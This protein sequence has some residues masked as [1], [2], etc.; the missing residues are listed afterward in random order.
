[1]AAHEADLLHL[2]VELRAIEAQALGYIQ[3]QGGDPE[4]EEAIRRWREDWKELK[5]RFDKKKKKMTTMTGEG[6]RRIVSLPLPRR[7][8]GGGGHDGEELN[9]SSSAM[10]SPNSLH[11]DGR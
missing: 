3:R 1:M 8:G 4:L 7:G 10:T 11:S 2:K 5:G 6:G 9:A